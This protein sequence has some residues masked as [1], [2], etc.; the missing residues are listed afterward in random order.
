MGFAGDQF[1]APAFLQRIMEKQPRQ[2]EKQGHVKRVDDAVHQLEPL[3]VELDACGINAACDVP[4]DL[5]QDADA[6]GVIHPGMPR[7]RSH[8]PGTFRLEGSQEKSASA[9]KLRAGSSMKR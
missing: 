3:L 4:V 6:L 7:R 5:Q 2:E 8:G 9:K 1:G